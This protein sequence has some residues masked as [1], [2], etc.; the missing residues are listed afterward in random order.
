MRWP[1]NFV[2]LLKGKKVSYEVKNFRDIVRIDGQDLQ[3]FLRDNV[4]KHEFIRQ[5]LLNATLTF[6]QRVK[7]FVKNIIMNIESP[8]KTKYHSYKVEFAM[9]GAAH[10]HGVLWVDLSNFDFLTA[11]LNKEL[12]D[13]CTPNDEDVDRC[14]LQS[15]FDRIRNE[16]IL[17]PDEQECLCNFADLF[18]TCSLKDVRTEDIVRDVQIHHHTK[19]CRKSGHMCRFDFPKFPSIKT[20]ISIPLH[21]QKLTEEEKKEMVSRSALVLKKVTA[22]LEDETIMDELA[23]LDKMLF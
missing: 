5:N 10:V 14:T 9:R 8:M 3:K 4:D 6:N 2:S 21:Q 18:I 15:L 23:K 17:L 13:D 19:C 12:R 1:E 7:M 20:I 11:N 16:E 22:V